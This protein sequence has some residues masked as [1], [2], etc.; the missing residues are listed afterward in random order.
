M[1]MRIKFTTV[2]KWSLILINVAAV[3]YVLRL[4]FFG[5]TPQSKC[6]NNS[7]SRTFKSPTPK[8]AIKHLSK[9]VTI[10]IQEFEL[11]DNDVTLTVKSFLNV[12]PSIEVLVLCSGIPYPPLDL[13]RWNS[14]FKNV[15]LIDTSLNLNV[16]YFASYSLVNV[17][18]KY[19]LFVPDSTR[20]QNRQSVQAMLSHAEKTSADIVAAP[21]NVQHALNCLKIDF[22]A[23]EWTVKYESI[24]EMVCDAVSGKHVAL[25]RMDVL[26]KLPNAFLVP[27]PQSL[28]L[29]TSNFNVKVRSMVYRN[30]LHAP[31]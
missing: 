1:I 8:L 30:S 9:L 14:S 24:K 27:F 25:V 31:S 11:N 19:V 4:N 17:K 18:T 6:Q 28:Y 12:F 26:R 20:I 3:Y 21:V 2:I 5:L 15:K 22:S 7:V 16:A 10:I 23:R 13:T 29:Q